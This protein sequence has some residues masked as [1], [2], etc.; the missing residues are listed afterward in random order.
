MGEWA[1]IKK[2]HQKVAKN[3]KIGYFCKISR[4]TVTVYIAMSAEAGR[5]ED[6]RITKFR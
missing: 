5:N 3:E 6:G 4:L 2:F 1:S